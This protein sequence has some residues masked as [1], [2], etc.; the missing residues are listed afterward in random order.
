MFLMKKV[1]LKNSRG[2][3]LA[4]DFYQSKSKSAIILSHGFLGDRHEWGKF[5]KTAEVLNNAGYN[6]VTF[7]FS[8][9]GESDDAKITLAKQVEDLRSVIS[10]LRNSGITEIGMLGL[11]NGALVS[12]LAY[13]ENIKSIVLWNPSTT[14]KSPDRILER[15]EIIEA[16]DWGYSAITIPNARRQ[17]VLV[18]SQFLVEKQRVNQKTLLER[19]NCPVLI[20]QGEKDEVNPVNEAKSAI[21]YLKKSK[22]EIIPGEGHDLK[23]SLDRVISFTLDWFR[24]HLIK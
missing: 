14:S 22:L 4:A 19:I 20:I 2:L 8:G 17:R 15:K 3:K 10:S 5:D 7:D 18:D 1:F 6:V 12:L 24:F 11:S 21:T 13:D 23:L 9:C 16:R